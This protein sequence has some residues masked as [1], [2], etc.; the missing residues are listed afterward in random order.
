MDNSKNCQGVTYTGTDY[1]SMAKIQ[2]E[3]EQKFY[4]NIVNPASERIILILKDYGL[5]I[6]ESARV[7]CAVQNKLNELSQKALV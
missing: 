3:E 1:L 2:K 7:I 4:K 5:T 6:N